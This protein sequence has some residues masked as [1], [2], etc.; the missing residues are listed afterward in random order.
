MSETVSPD[1]MFHDASERLDP[2]G[3]VET[4]VVKNRAR[5]GSARPSSLLYTYGPGAIM[6]LP[7]F[8][9]LPPGPDVWGPVL[10]RRAC[11]PGRVHLVQ[12]H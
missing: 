11:P 6:D 12:S 5:V 2:L 8:A 9:G 4:G 1:E 10:R 7:G 3:D